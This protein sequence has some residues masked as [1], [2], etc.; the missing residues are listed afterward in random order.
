M[1]LYAQ[2]FSLYSALAGKGA[3]PAQR[4]PLFAG[5]ANLTVAERLAI[6]AEQYF[7]RHRAALAEDFPKLEKLVGEARFTALASAYLRAHPPNTPS[8]SEFGASLSTFIARAP[9]LRLRSDAGDLSRLEWARTT[10]FLAPDAPVASRDALVHLGAARI[11]HAQLEIVPSVRAINLEFDVLPLWRSLEEG[12][13]PPRPRR[14]AAA[15][16]VW[17]RGFRVFH[18]PVTRTEARA[19]RRASRRQPLHRVISSW[20]H[21]GAAPRAAFEAISSWFAEEMVARV[22]EGPA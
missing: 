11:P 14:Q 3:A 21:S 4:D 7:W 13:R 16:V 8:I 5:D 17:R 22:L 20:G 10:A 18:A 2:Q 6:Y 9:A 15:V 1:T 12:S 19:L